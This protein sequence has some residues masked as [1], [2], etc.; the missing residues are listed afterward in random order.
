MGGGV[1]ARAR[2]CSFGD[3]RGTTATSRAPPSLSLPRLVCETRARD[4][5][6]A[7]TTRLQRALVLLLVVVVDLDA[8]LF[9]RVALAQLDDLFVLFCLMGE[10]EGVCVGDVFL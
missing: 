10:G 9:V 3:R 5:R 7:R 6:R 8:E 4:G 2:R 1:A